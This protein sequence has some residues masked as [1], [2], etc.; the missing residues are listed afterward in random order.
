[1]IVKQV[2]RQDHSANVKKNCGYECKCKLPGFFSR[3]RNNLGIGSV[4]KCDV[5]DQKYVLKYI[6]GATWMKT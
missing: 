1:M 3:Y 6:Y 4:V 2:T 5:C